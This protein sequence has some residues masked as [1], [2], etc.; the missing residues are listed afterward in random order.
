MTGGRL[1]KKGQGRSKKGIIRGRS[2]QDGSQ[3]YKKGNFQI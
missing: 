3:R 2:G 1:R